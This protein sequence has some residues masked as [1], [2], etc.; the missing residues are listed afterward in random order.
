MA[1]GTPPPPF[2]QILCGVAGHTVE[3]EQVLRLLGVL[4]NKQSAWAV[5]TR[6]QT[7][8]NI[9]QYARSDTQRTARGVHGWL[10]DLLNMFGEQV[11]TSCELV[12][13]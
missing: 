9:Q 11:G 10:L 6:H 13:Y 1:L 4:L 2:P 12:W 8:T 7:A 5:T 3:V